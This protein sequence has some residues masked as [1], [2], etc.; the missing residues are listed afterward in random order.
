[1]D[2][3]QI[4]YIRALKDTIKKMKKQATDYLQI[5]YMIKDLHLEY[6]KNPYNSIT[7]R[8]PNLKIGKRFV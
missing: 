8:Q 4:K 7:R 6:I 3:I 2:F 5:I 1:M